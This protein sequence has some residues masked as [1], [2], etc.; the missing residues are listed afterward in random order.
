[1]YKIIFGAVLFLTFCSKLC[2][3][4]SENSNDEE[5]SFVPTHE[6]QVVKKGQK[7]PKGLHV[8]VNFES[9]ITE[10]KLLD[11]NTTEET[12]AVV[13]VPDAENSN[14]ENS[15]HFKL[16]QEELKEALKNIKS[17]EIK[18][19]KTQKFRSYEEL[20]DDLSKLNIRPKT[21]FELLKEL[22][23]LHKKLQKSNENEELL[24][25]I[26]EDLEYL[27]HQIDNANDFVTLNGF[28][29]IIYPNLN[30]TGVDIKSGTLKLFGS[31]VQNNA[32][33]QIHALE[34]GAIGILLKVLVLNSDH[35]IK[36]RAIYALSSLMR[37][38]PLAQTQFLDSAG[39]NVFEELLQKSNN[40]KLLL[41]IVTLIHDL[42]LEH[43]DA[44]RDTNDLEKIKQYNAVN[45][46]RRL[47]D[48]NWCPYLV[49]LLS[50]IIKVDVGDHDAVEKI[51]N[52]IISSDVCNI[53]DNLQLQT[54]VSHLQSYY[55]DIIQ[56]DDDTYFQQLLGL[57][58]TLV[59]PL[60]HKSEL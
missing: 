45:L 60:K 8:R 18:E 16:S 6:W 35:E 3:K 39:L 58:N 10:A 23:L 57:C 54:L 13:Q 21:D 52:A 30:S 43:N 41:K 36:N 51:L 53:L 37:R 32:K 2:V 12:K 4:C 46:K 28:V 31:S 47:R 17:E 26:I 7:I 48:Q 55:T 22:V 33:V 25:S 15:A 27:L 50:S 56:F 24:V 5:D 38:F 59:R 29:D 42:I 34:T 19:E 11:E 40:I 44:L 9:G 49:T 1:M 20:K 14:T